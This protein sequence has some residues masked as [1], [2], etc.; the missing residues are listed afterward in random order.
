MTK[1]NFDS[2]CIAELLAAFERGNSE[3]Q[4]IL[5]SRLEKDLHRMADQIAFGLSPD[6]REDVVQK[7]WMN[8]L[9]GNTEYNPSRSAP[10]TYLSLHM[11][12]AIRQVRSS[13]ARAGEPKRLSDRGK[14]EK[15]QTIPIDE[16]PISCTGVNASQEYCV[17][18]KLVL[19]AAERIFEDQT[20]TALDRL[21]RGFTQEQ[22]ARAA[23][24]SRRTF[25]RRIS[26][27]RSYL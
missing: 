20:A 2:S 24:Y 5:P 8:V 10:L 1:S 16:A 13:Y 17:D 25:G 9:E 19:E 21:S 15:A 11:R 23:G 26:S 6:Q 22:A 7:T 18:A 3:A 14:T 12:N 27:L 4:K